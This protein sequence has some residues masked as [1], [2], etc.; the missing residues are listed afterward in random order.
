MQWLDDA[1]TSEASSWAL[2]WEMNC[3]GENAKARS[4]QVDRMIVLER[5]W[6]IMSKIS[7]RRQDLFIARIAKSECNKQAIKE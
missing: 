3:C 6:K 7:Q 4:H 2:A 1:S 5:K